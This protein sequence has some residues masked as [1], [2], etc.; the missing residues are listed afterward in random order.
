MKVVNEVLPSDPERIAEIKE[1]TAQ[2]R[3]RLQSQKADKT[4][5]EQFFEDEVRDLEDNGEGCNICH[6]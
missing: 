2:R 4:L 5:M 6:L 3:E 1:R